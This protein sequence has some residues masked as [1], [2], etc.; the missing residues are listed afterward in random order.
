[1]EIR[2]ESQPFN[3]WKKPAEQSAGQVQRFFYRC[4]DCLIVV[5]LDHRP[6]PFAECDTCR[7]DTGAAHMEFMGQVHRDKLVKEYDAPAC[8]DRCTSARGPSCEC[9][10]LGQNHGSHL[11]VTVRI[12]ND[13]PVVAAAPKD[14]AKYRRQSEA[15]RAACLQAMDLLKQK[16]S[17]D[18][19]KFHAPRSW[20]ENRDAW[21]GIHYGLKAINKVQNDARA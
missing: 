9:K 6:A 19:E 18:W 17:A 13:I 7:T 20:V 12:E 16:Y 3:Y 5:A 21:E 15:F 1:M 10:C 4:P 14:G 11:W 8:D 2:S